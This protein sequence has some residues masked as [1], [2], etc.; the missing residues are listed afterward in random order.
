[1]ADGPP[2]DLSRVAQIVSVERDDRSTDFGTGFCI[3]AAGVS[4]IFITAAHVVFGRKAGAAPRLVR[5]AGNIATVV[6]PPEHNDPADLVVLR[7]DSLKKRPPRVV[8]YEGGYP[9]L[10][11]TVAGRARQ[12][13]EKDFARVEVRARLVKLTTV[14]NADSGFEAERWVLERVAGEPISKGISGGPVLTDDGRCLGVLVEALDDGQEGYAVSA[15]EVRRRLAEAD[16][17]AVSEAAGGEAKEEKGGLGPVFLGPTRIVAPER[18]ALR[19]G[20]AGPFPFSRKG[21]TFRDLEALLADRL[22]GADALGLL[23]L[24]CSF[25]ADAREALHRVASWWSARTGPHGSGA[26]QWVDGD[27]IVKAGAAQR[28]LW[29]ALAAGAFAHDPTPLRFDRLAAE[30]RAG[31]AT[32]F[33]VDF[34][35]FRPD[36]FERA[37]QAAKVLQQVLAGPLDLGAHGLVI[38]LPG[39]LRAEPCLRGWLEADERVFDTAPLLRRVPPTLP[40]AAVV[41]GRRRPEATLRTLLAPFANG[42][43]PTLR[44]ECGAILAAEP[45]GAEARVPG[46]AELFRIAARFWTRGLA[47]PAFRL[48]VSADARAGQQ[49]AGAV[50]LLADFQRTLAPRGTSCPTTTSSWWGSRGVWSRGRMTSPRSAV[51]S[52]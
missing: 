5:I 22:G 28:D 23:L 36:E 8:F 16:L 47:E 35:R 49:E 33:L 51:A 48:E 3:D 46:Y 32:T 43:S 27:N 20:A 19:E 26:V 39:F 34:S 11:V 6:F 38:G 25:A 41:D 50:P 14:E 52:F 21:R 30:L 17:T 45:T 42:P 10:E 12:A 44:D 40:P 24:V 15:A 18:P 2:Y 13:G 29:T 7:V 9:G 4:A 37:E 31:D 1:M